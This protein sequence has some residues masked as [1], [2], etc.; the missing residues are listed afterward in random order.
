MTPRYRRSSVRA[1]LESFTQNH[2]VASAA[3][4][5]LWAV[6]WNRRYPDVDEPVWSQEAA[7][8][9]Q[10][11][12]VRELD[13]ATTLAGV[14]TGDTLIAFRLTGRAP[15]IG[16][17]VRV[18]PAVAKDEWRLV[19]VQPLGLGI[20]LRFDDP[21]GPGEPGWIETLRE[22]LRQLRTSLDARRDRLAARRAQLGAKNEPPSVEDVWRD[23]VSA[24]SDRVAMQT[25]Y[26]PQE[27]AALAR[28]RAKGARSADEEE[29]KI[30][31]ARKR[32]FTERGNEEIARFRETQWPAIRDAAAAEVK[33]Y[34]DYRTEVV[35][36]EDALNRVRS[37]ATRAKN[38]AAA[39]DRLEQSGFRI[40]ALSLDASR[41]D[42]AEYAEEILT[43]IELLHAAIPPRAQTSA[44]P[45]SAYRAPTA[46]P[47]V[48]PPRM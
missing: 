11:T 8:A 37:Y 46:G 35:R 45:F 28:A 27:H 4:D 2:A 9:G 26:T 23:E 12:W 15:A 20:D 42:D 40:N 33:K 16:S 18:L 22:A 10:L 7:Y 19:E 29:K 6:L 32:R 38:A 43:T 47:S 41:L 21:A 34:A 39:L 5:A 48:T 25:D 44:A 30:V 17:R 36:L 24:I 13:A 31:A 3:H 14:D 1:L